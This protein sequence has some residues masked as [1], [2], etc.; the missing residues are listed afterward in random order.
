[1]ESG[2][3]NS[4]EAERHPQRHILTAALGAGGEVVADSPE[5]PVTLESGD[6]L[7]LC[8]DGLWGLVQEPEI[9]KVVEEHEA[10]AACSELVKMARERGGP[11]NITVQILRL[12]ANGSSCH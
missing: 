1:V 7:I 4:D 2:I 6:T 3:L 11:D 5:T 8:T 9:L 10:A 12:S